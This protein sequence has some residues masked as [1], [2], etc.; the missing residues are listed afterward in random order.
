MVSEGSSI[1]SWSRD[2][3]CDTLVKSA[4]FYACPKDLPETEFLGDFKTTLSCSH[5]SHLQQKRA[6]VAEI[7]RKCT[8]LGEKEHLEI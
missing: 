5:Y 8:V 4:T 2:H 6:S 3:S 1:S 7:H